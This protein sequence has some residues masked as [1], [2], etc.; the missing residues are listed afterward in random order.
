[1]SAKVLEFERPIVELES[2]IRELK[3]LSVGN[4][5]GTDMAGE[6][7]RLEEKAVQLQRERFAALTP[8]EQLQLAKHPDRPYTLDYIGELLTDFVELRGDRTFG[9]D[10]AIVAGLAR[11]EGDPVVVM[12]QQK[13]AARPRRSRPASRRWRASRCRRS[14]SSS[15]RAARAGRW[16]S[17]SPT[18]SSCSSTRC[19]R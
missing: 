14:R 1:M 11:F 15:A 6:I 19:T 18:A 17:G 10:P 12:G 8:W 13:S 7:A 2:K 16:R 9:D 3:T 4:S 5:A